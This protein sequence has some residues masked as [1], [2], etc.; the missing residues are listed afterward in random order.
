MN[1]QS[2][3]IGT[4]VSE[5]MDYMK[6]ALVAINSMEKAIDT[7]NGISDKVDNALTYEI[8]RLY[9]PL[10]NG[11]KYGDKVYVIYDEKTTPMCP[12]CN[13]KKSVPAM[14]GPK[15]ATVICPECNGEGRVRRVTRQIRSMEVTGI[16]VE[17]HND[18]FP[19][20]NLKITSFCNS[21]IIPLH[22]VYVD[23]KTCKDKID[24][25]NKKDGFGLLQKTESNAGK[26]DE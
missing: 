6:D 16:C 10:T 13:G 17:F 5:A 12:V 14:I 26:G 8:N 9:E 19:T 21:L 22:E 15:E 11:I 7:L 1:E 18:K 23:S 20:V 4:D 25:L 3:D 2:T 24:E